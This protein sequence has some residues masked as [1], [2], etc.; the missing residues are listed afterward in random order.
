MPRGGLRLRTAGACRAAVSVEDCAGVNALL[1]PAGDGSCRPKQQ[2][3][4]TGLTPILDGGLCRAMQARDCVAP[5]PFLD[6]ATNQCREAVA[7]DCG[8]DTP[9]FDSNTCRAAV[10]ADCDG[11]ATPDLL[12]G[13]CYAAC[14]SG[15]PVR[16][17]TTRLCRIAEASDCGGG[18]PVFESGVCRAQRAD[19]CTGTTPILDGGACRGAA[20]D[21]DCGT[22]NIVLV[23][24]SDGSCR[25]R[26]ATD[27]VAG[28]TPI[29]DDAKICRAALSQ[30]ECTAKDRALL[31]ETGGTCRLRTQADC[32]DVQ[33]LDATSGEC[34]AIVAA[35][36]TDGTPIFEDNKCRAAANQDDCTAKA[37]SLLYIGEG[38]CRTRVQ[39]D[40]GGAT[41]FLDAT[42]GEC[43][44]VTSADCP[45]AQPILD[46]TTRAC[47]VAANQ[48]ECTAKDTIL[49]FDGGAC[50]PRVASDC[51]ATEAFENGFCRTRT[52]QDCTGGT[53][54]FDSGYCFPE[55][56][57]N[58]NFG[59]YFDF[60]FSGGTQT[61]GRFVV[62][63]PTAAQAR[64]D[65]LAA[66]NANSDQVVSS[67]GVISRPCAEAVAGGFNGCIDTATSNTGT[68]LIR[69]FGL[70]DTPAA[71]KA[72]REAK[73]SFWL[74]E[75]AACNCG[76][77][78][79]VADSNAPNGCRAAQTPADCTGTTP[80]LD[81][82][83]C[84]AATNQAEC[85]AK[86][87][88]LVFDGGSCRPR[89]AGDCTGDTPRF[90]G[91]H[92]F[93]EEAF[94]NHGVYFTFE[95][96]ISG[97]RYNRGRF[98]VNRPTQ[99]QARTD[100][101]ALCN[102]E[103]SG[104]TSARIIRGCS[105]ATEAGRFVCINTANVNSQT[106]FGVGATPAAAKAAREAK[107]SGVGSG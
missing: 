20:T 15:T 2:S 44:A 46:A 31:F 1:L 73:G 29:F 61:G 68:G 101:L 65:A 40:C 86:G 5:T 104:F 27:C 94:L 49:Q 41:P 97:T 84:R 59:A 30:E 88:N 52:S 107:H 6:L 7:A 106:Y 21:A 57:F 93:A 11:T 10:Q 17:S 82:G 12:N 23:R 69:H 19:E 62:N 36:C 103:T 24:V 72:A 58:S 81:G 90:D 105:E 83:F 75:S 60:E 102:T 87:G 35:D 38:Q 43:R 71:A 45:M 14:P 74:Q 32:T 28:P 80:I 25:E 3:D 77:A 37:T 98:V 89:V 85:T 16:D 79:P 54:R 55:S 4:C 18:T 64:T 51:A 100:A 99:A 66:C 91:G 39:S 22:I 48:E 63:R 95:V 26:V 53:P 67:G 13:R 96:E 92:C 42:S 33:I 34:R 50:R 56:A 70:G 9:I 78:M 47:R 76:G 8:G